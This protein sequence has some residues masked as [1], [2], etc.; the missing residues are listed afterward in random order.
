MGQHFTR[1]RST[2][3]QIGVPD[4]KVWV[5]GCAFSPNRPGQLDLRIAQKSVILPPYPPYVCDRFVTVGSLTDAW[6]F[7][8]ASPSRLFAIKSSSTGGRRVGVRLLMS[9]RC[10]ISDWHRM[11]SRVLTIIN[12]ARSVQSADPEDTPRGCTATAPK[13]AIMYRPIEFSKT[14]CKMLQASAARYITR[15]VEAEKMFVTIGCRAAADT[16]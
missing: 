16:G 1:I 7:S 5:A 11:N 14:P 3:T 13:N 4:S 12:Y 2:L 10:E 6:S 9:N 8:S 15:F